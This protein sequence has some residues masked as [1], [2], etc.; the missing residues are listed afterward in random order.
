MTRATGR[1]LN[2]RITRATANIALNGVLTILGNPKRIPVQ[3]HST[4]FDQKVA[5][6]S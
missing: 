6:E 4:V 5:Y 1:F 2:V 3:K